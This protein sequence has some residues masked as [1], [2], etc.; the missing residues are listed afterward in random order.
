MYHVHSPVAG[1]P[2]V[3]DNDSHPPAEVFSCNSK[4][5]VVN[6]ACTQHRL[7]GGWSINPESDFRIESTY[8]RQ[9][10]QAMAK[11]TWKLFQKHRMEV[12][13]Y[14]ALI[15]V[16]L[17]IAVLLVFNW[18]HTVLPIRILGIA[19]IV[20][21][22]AVIPLGARRAQAKTCRKAIRDA[23]KRGEYPARVEF[24]FQDDHIRTTVGKEATSVRYREVSHLAALKDWRFL[25]FGQGAYIIP[26]SAFRDAAE[27][28]RFDTF[29]T[30][31]CGMPIVILE[32][33]VP[34]S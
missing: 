33:E 6:W 27:L 12:M 17:V 31:K 29:I 32:G 22:F 11:A 8:D 10:Y 28:D 26:V 16:A 24:L 19:F 7:E 23:E 2:D 15:S 1:S 21:Q 4:F 30:G 13:A 25:Y 20:L 5:G 9:A 3:P 34:K 18:N 14:P